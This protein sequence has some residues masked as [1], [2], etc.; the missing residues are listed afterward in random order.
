M[1]EEAKNSDFPELLEELASLN[2]PMRSSDLAAGFELLHEYSASETLS[3]LP[4]VNQSKQKSRFEEAAVI[5][6][7]RQ[8]T[9]RQISATAELGDFT[10]KKCYGIQPHFILAGNGDVKTCQQLKKLSEALW[11]LSAQPQSLI[12]SSHFMVDM[13]MK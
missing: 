6:E 10:V 12:W 3:A 5:V 11:P 4:V 2:V 8:H 7:G 13:V 1:L 9:P